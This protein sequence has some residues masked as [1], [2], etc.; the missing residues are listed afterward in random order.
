MP[1]LVGVWRPSLPADGIAAVIAKQLSLVATPVTHFQQY[2]AV[3][4]GF[5]VGLQD[6]GILE[7]GPQPAVSPDGSVLVV[8]DGELSNGPELRALFKRS[9]PE[10]PLTDPELCLHLV[11]AHGV[12]VVERFNGLFVLVVYD[13]ARRRLTLISDRFGFRPLFY[14]HTPAG[15]TFGSEMKALVAVDPE[16]RRLDEIGTLEMFSYGSHFFD[17]TWMEG[18]L[19]LA[20]GTI[21]T[22]DSD[23]LQS[24]RYWVYQYEETAPRLDQATYAT[25]FGVL[26]DRAVERCMRGA[27][28]V[29]IF[30]SGGY[31][32]RSVAASIRPHHKPLPAFTFGHPESRDVRYGSLLAQRL[33]LAH[34]TLT[35][36][37]PYLLQNCRAIVWRT[38]GLLPFSH[39]TS[40]RYHRVFKQ[41]MDIILTGFLA[42]FGGSHTW[43]QL[44]RARSRRAAVD[45]IYQRFLGGGL[46]SAQRVFNRA[47]FQRTKEAVRQRFEESFEHVPNAHPLNVA[48]SWNVTYLQPRG[49]Y[50][51]PSVDRHLFETRAPHMDFEL[52]DFLLKI[53]P[54]ARL[55]Q[56]VYKRMIAYRFPEI[57][58]IPCTNSGRPINP[59]FARE[60]ALM[61]GRYLARAAVAPL[62]RAFSRREPLGRSFRDLNEDFRAE[63]E[64][65]TDLLEPMLRDGMFPSAM[66]DHVG[67][68]EV[69][70]EHYGQEAGHE[71]LLGRLISWGLGTKYLFHDDLSD[72]PADLYSR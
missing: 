25:V 39:L 70:K 26:L 69:I 16:P 63:P 11:I 9:L 4:P 19:R 60:Y 46:A 52:V 38:E 45:A 29:G 64:L 68:R 42:E 5:G 44:L 37:G 57:R 14:R 12:E 13:L 23:G 3:F 32:S 56:R 62:R 41:Q 21:L 65:V 28:R 22:V 34:R 47:F 43:P 33:G 7:N 18:Y 67:I 49:T 51:S 8:L 55:E 17:R 1:N 6:H 35:G 10:K 66:F 71:A 2:S 59:S 24:R 53:P 31:D 54:Y 30:L 58:D 48:D 61:T 15:V 40:V 72:V 27:H 36:D 20:P 50:Q